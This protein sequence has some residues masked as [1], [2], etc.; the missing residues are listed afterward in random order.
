MTITIIGGS[1]F[2]GTRLAKRL[3]DAGHTVRI[4]DKRRSAAYPEL[5]TRCD[6]RNAPDGTDEYPESL[7]DA[8]GAP[9]KDAEARNAM[10]MRSLLDALRGSDAVVNLAAEHR[11]DV[12]PRSLY[13]EVNV[14]G[15][16]NVCAACAALK[17]RRIIFTSSVAVYGFAPPGTDETGGIHYFNDYGR[18]KWL[19]E[20]EHR[21][22]LKDN[23]ENCAVIVRPTVIFGEGNRGNVYNLLR[24]IA[25]GRFPMV[26]RGT[27]RKSMNYVE[28]VA[29]F[30]EWC[31]AHETGS[32]ERLYNYCDGPAY[33]MNTLVLD[34]YRAL[35][36]PRRRLVHFPYPLAYLGGLC[37]DLLALVTWRKFAVSAIRVRKF[38]QETYFTSGRV[39]A[40]GFVPP[41]S[42]EEGL[43]RTIDY[44]FVRKVDGHT[45]C[46]E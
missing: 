28:N 34:V 26:G 9:G 16:R 13:D 15:S 19:A 38:T 21:A 39:P 7:T 46:G 1:G 30:V 41:V 10:P 6:I 31:L 43:R 42:L 12:T 29:A 35:G 14:L 33:D 5:W 25:G 17:I 37:F 18:T 2:L 3:L 44:E 22:W 32:G 11:D 4:A 36:R 23:L 27:N 40:T 45:F 20:E 8:A 24:Q